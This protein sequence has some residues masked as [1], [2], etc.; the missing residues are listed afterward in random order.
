MDKTAVYLDMPGDSTLHN[1]GEKTNIIRTTGHKKDKVTVIL[2]AVMIHNG[3]RDSPAS[4]VLRGVL[5]KMPN[6]RL[7][8]E[9]ILKWWVVQGV[10]MGKRELVA[11]LSLSSYENEIIWSQ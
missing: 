1:K 3:K 9:H 8:N 10:L 4:E 7:V 2:A 11:L 5:V 6:N